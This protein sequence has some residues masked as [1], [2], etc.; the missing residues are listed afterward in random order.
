MKSVSDGGFYRWLP[1]GYQPNFVPIESCEPSAGAPVD[2]LTGI[3]NEEG[4]AFARL[5]DVVIDKQGALLLTDDPG[6]LVRRVASQ[7]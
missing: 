5:V 2:V 1:S 3:L 7:S 4:S 6:N